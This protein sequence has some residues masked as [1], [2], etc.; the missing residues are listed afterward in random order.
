MKL[1][2][3]PWWF[4]ST[5]VIKSLGDPQAPQSSLMVPGLSEVLMDPRDP[6]APTG[7]WGPQK[8]LSLHNST[9]LQG[10]PGVLSTP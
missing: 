7:H 1:G 4:L 2:P 8:S 9:G 5:R 3:L 10:S 6:G